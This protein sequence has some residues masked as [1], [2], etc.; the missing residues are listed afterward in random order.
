MMGT[1]CVKQFFQC[2]GVEVSPSCSV[3]M[4]AL[5]E[6]MFYCECTV[7]IGTL[8]CIFLIEMI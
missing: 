8:W 7:T 2:T 5:E 6:N 4:I 1:D 3:I